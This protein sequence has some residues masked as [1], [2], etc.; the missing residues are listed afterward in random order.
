MTYV[1]V[2]RSDCSYCTLATELLKKNGVA[3]TCYSLESSRWVLDLFKKADIKTVPQVWDSKGNHIGG[4]T[5]L[6]KHLEGD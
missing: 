4:Y 6:Q 3:Y 5:E 1:V 2:S